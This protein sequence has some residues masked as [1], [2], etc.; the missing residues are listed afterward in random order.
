MTVAAILPFVAAAFAV[1]S[2]INDGSTLIAM[3]LKITSLKPLMAIGLLSGAVVTGP[4][5]FGTQVATTLAGRLVS[6]EGD[7]GDA[8]LLAAVIAALSIVAMLSRR[9][10]PT[11]LTLALMGGI[12]G[13]GV[14][15]RLPVSWETIALVLAIGAA[16]PIVGGVGGFVF[17]RS[18]IWYMPGRGAATTRIGWAHRL[19]FG[20]QCLAYSVNDGQKMLAIFAVAAGTDSGSLPARPGQLLAIGVLFTLGVLVGLRRSAAT[21]STGVMLMR[22]TNTVAAEFSSA[23]AVFGTTALGAPVSMTQSAAA[24]LV[25][26]GL[27]EGYGKIRWQAASRIALAWVFTL[28]AAAVLAAIIARFGS[29]VS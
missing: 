13:A 14:G 20:F 29:A 3:G 19:A 5:L 12:A 24:A 25:G 16:A 15:Y 2:G 9:G 6:F 23:A 1:V 18:L 26:S 11:S 8:A 7:A 10:L 28:P 22:P 17:S 4:V 27:S 21:L